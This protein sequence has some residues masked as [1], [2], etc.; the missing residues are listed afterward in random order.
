MQEGTG[1]KWAKAKGKKASEN[2]S[3]KEGVEAVGREAHVRATT[4]AEARTVK[5]SLSI[6]S[7]L[8]CV[9]SQLRTTFHPIASGSHLT[10][11]RLEQM[12]VGVT[13]RFS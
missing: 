10:Q 12:S 1:K 2:V 4:P 11:T 8:Y 6:Q 5:L 9:E 3:R 7:R 13:W